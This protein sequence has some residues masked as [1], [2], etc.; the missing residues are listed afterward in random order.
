MEDIPIFFMVDFMQ[1]CII[2]H[3]NASF[4]CELVIPQ[5][6]LLTLQLFYN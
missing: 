3:V 1:A 5:H 4:C 2:C 6:L